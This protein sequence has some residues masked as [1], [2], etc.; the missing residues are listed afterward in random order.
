MIEQDVTRL[1]N[2]CIVLPLAAFKIIYG[3]KKLANTCL[4]TA[5]KGNEID[6]YSGVLKNPMKTA[7]NSGVALQGY[8]Q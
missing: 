1:T 6:Q 5:L 3:K 7:D 4:Y 8:I 2:L